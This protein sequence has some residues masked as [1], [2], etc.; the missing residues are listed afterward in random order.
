MG[1][2]TVSFPK[3]A[4]QQVLPTAGLAIR[5]KD[6][7]I[8]RQYPDGCLTF[9]I[10]NKRVGTK[11]IAKRPYIRHTRKILPTLVGA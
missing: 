4:W 5:P 11:P 1:N 3:A 8:V 6:A 10:R 2:F 7:V 9:T